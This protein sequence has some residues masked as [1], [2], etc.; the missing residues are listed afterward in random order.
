MSYGRGAGNMDADATYLR[1]LNS[2]QHDHVEFALLESPVRYEM[3]WDREGGQ[4]GRSRLCVFDVFRRRGVTA[5]RD[6]CRGCKLEWDTFSSQY[7]VCWAPARVEVS[8]V[9]RCEY[10]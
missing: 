2:E 10:A 6:L 8:D 7:T 5:P 1:L 4:R 3:H 9:R